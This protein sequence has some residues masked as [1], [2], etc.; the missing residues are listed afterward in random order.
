MAAEIYIINTLPDISFADLE[1]DIS[2]SWSSGSNDLSDDGCETSSQGSESSSLLLFEN[3]SIEATEMQFLRCEDKGQV[4]RLLP[5]APSEVNDPLNDDDSGDATINL[6]E[7]NSYDE[8]SPFL[9]DDPLFSGSTSL[10]ELGEW[11]TGTIATIPRFRNNELRRYNNEERQQCTFCGK[12]EK[13]DKPH[14][15]C[16]LCGFATYCRKKCLT[17]D[18]QRHCKHDCLVCERTPW[19]SI[20]R[21][22]KN[23]LDL[24]E[25][26]Q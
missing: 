22:K 18:R 4:K 23:F 20:E 2:V 1:D 13:A 5:F 11:K 24:N 21:N 14:I 15:R 26:S 8:S 16:E 7:G 25:K 17:R 10:C 3:L 12:Y 19:F 9:K 6:Y